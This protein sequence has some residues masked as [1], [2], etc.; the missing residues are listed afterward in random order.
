MF[1]YASDPEVTRYLIWS[2]HKS[3]V[4][5]LEFIES[6]L[7]LYRRRRPA[8]LGIELKATRKI[9]G[10]CD[11]IRWWPEHWRSEIGYALARQ[12]WGQGLMTEAVSALIKYGFET[13]GINRIQAMAEL[14]NIGS[15]RVM[16]KAGMAYEGILRQY[17]IQH[18][19]FRDMKIYAILRQDWDKQ[20]QLKP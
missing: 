5:S 9:V 15:T 7:E 20:Q 1:I 11:F 12:Y 8:P 3:V 2:P 14:P 16:E 4:N 19:Q 18:E 6:A 13:K 17:M 10:T